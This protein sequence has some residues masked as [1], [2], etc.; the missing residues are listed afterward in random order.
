MEHDGLRVDQPVAIPSA[1]EARPYQLEGEFLEVC[2]CYTICPCWT[3]RAP[4]ENE[5]TGIFAWAVRTGTIDGVD[6]SGRTVASI[7]THQGHRDNSHQRVVLFLDAQ[8]TQEQADKLASTFSGSFGGP[9]AELRVLLGELLAV[10][11]AEIR[12]ERVGRRTSLTI[13]RVVQSET[14]DLIASSRGVVMLENGRLSEVLSSR[15]KVATAQH[16]RVGMPGNGIDIDVRQ[17]SAMRGAFN[18]DYQPAGS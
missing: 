17:R 5:C 16:F 12:I 4:D 15:A 11:R 10:Q 7:S 3:G 13:D 9:L 2:D 6:V 8:C 14:I 18:Y 1:I